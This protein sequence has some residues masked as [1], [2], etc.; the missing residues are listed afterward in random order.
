MLLLLLL[1]LQPDA[2]VNRINEGCGPLMERWRTD[3]HSARR[4]QRKR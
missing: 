2:P 1:L 3:E 4:R